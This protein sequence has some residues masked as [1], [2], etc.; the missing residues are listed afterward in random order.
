MLTTE[1]AKPG[2]AVP[3]SIWRKAAAAG[4][5]ALGAAGWS[6]ISAAQTADG[7]AVYREA[8]CIGCHKWHGEGGGG[9]GGAALSLRETPLER[10]DLI[11]VIRC[12]RPATGMPYHLRTAWK[13]TECYGMTAVDIG[14]D[15]PPQAA[16]FLRD[17]EIEA[18]TDYVIE[19]LQGRGAPTRDEC[20]AF[21]GEGAR[22]CARF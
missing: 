15:V 1:L 14:K 4:L 16:A 19:H 11:D 10:Q 18:V 13:S 12:G 17:H 22:E 9:Y 20:I 8:N 3:G 6:A 7:K 5:I 21:W 2:A